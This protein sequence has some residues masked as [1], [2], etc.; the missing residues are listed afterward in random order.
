MNSQAA[1]PFKII[2]W[3]ADKSTKAQF[4]AASTLP[5]HTYVSACMIIAITDEGKIAMSKPERGW[6]L[7]GGHTEKGETPEQC[8]R[9]EAM[10]EAAVELGE[11]MYIG[12]WGINKIFQ[13][14]HNRDYPDSTHMPLYI[15]RIKAVHDFTPQFEVSERCF[16]EPY[17]MAS[18]HHKFEDFGDIYEYALKI[19]ETMD[20]H[21]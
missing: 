19:I 14:E 12:H 7:L 9:R 11:L 5:P 3:G 2:Y 8:I 1:Q 17:E 16:I 10:E 18:Y 6:G 15:S 21:G 20:P 13:S 4:Q